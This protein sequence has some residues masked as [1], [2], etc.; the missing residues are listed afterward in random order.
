MTCLRGFGGLWVVCAIAVA[1]TQTSDYQ[2]YQD[3]LTAI[4]GLQWQKALSGFQGMSAGNAQ[5]EGALYWKAF[6]LYK[7]GRGRDGLAPI[8]ELKKTYPQSGWLPDAE[9][10]ANAISKNEGAASTAGKEATAETRQK[11]LEDR[12]NA[13]TAHAPEILR[14]AAF[15]MDLPGVRQK[16]LYTLSSERSPE[17]RKIVLEVARGAAN[18]DLQSYAISQLGKSDPQA[19]FDLYPSVDTGVKSFILAVLASN[20]ESARLMKIA[21]TEKSDD[22][23]YQALTNLVE[24]GSEAQV[25]QSLQF[26]NASD[27]KMLVQKRLAN[28]HQWVAD[29]LAALQTSKDARERRIGAIG[30][31]RGGDE[32]TGR[33]LV[34]AYA[35]EKDPE[36]K[37]AIVFALGERKDFAA[38]KTMDK[39]ET[40]PGLKRR[41]SMALENAGTK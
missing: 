18:P 14:A 7:A 35:S 37:G 29:Q 10:L 20:R 4:D 32:S 39:N 21:A 12:V 2:K 5:A 40:D 34:A 25:T 38:L 19:A 13:D 11:A 3:S 22:L 17:A 6:A 27:V 26:E 24:V 8:A 41:L 30:L 23:R 9:T 36:V 28:L 15:G 33:A 1:Q 16:A 31:T